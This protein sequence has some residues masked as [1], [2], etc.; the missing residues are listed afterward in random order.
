MSV[1]PKWLQLQLVLSVWYIIHQL[2]QIVLR[3]WPFL[4]RPIVKVSQGRVRGVTAK[5]PNGRRYHYF[6]S[7]PYCKPPVGELRFRPPV[8]LERFEQPVLN[9][10]YERPD[11]IHYQ[12]PLDKFIFGTESSLHLSVFT[13]GLPSEGAS[14]YPVIVFLPSGGFRACTNS[15]FI[16][17]PEPIVLEGVVVVTVGY[18]V[19]PLGF[20][21]LPDAGIS[22]NAGLKDQRLALKWV[23]ENINQF[24]GDAGNVTLMGLSAGAWSAYL[25]YL[26]PNSRKYFHRIICQSGDACTDSVFQLDPEE[27]A[28]KLAQLLGCRGSTDRDVLD[29]LT[30]A[31]AKLLTKLQKKICSS[32][33]ISCPMRFIFRPVIERDLTADS[34]ICQ[35]P[36]QI[37]KSYDTLRMPIMSNL[38][39]AE[40]V[41]G[42]MMSRDRLDQYNQEE[43]LVPQFLGHS[44]K[45]DRQ[46]V[47]NEVKQFYFGDRKV[48]QSSL[49]A[50][51]DFMTDCTFA[52]TSCLSAEWIARYQPNVEHYFSYFSYNGR[53]NYAKAVLNVDVKEASHGDDLYYLFSAPFVKKLPKDSDE[54]R[55]RE[56]VVKAVTNFAKCGNPTP[57]ESLLGFQWRPVAPTAPN[58]TK[59]DL[60]SLE[61]N[62]PPRMIRNPNPERKEFW[63]KMIRENTNLLIGSSCCRVQPGTMTLKWAKLQ[64]VIVLWYAW[65]QLKQILLRFWPFL[66]RPIVEV[67]QGGVQG[68]TARLPNGV[69]YHYFKC[70]PYSKAPVG[71]LRFRS[72]V[73]LERFEQP[74]LD[75]SYERPDFVQIQ[76]P[77]DLRVVGVESSL[78]LS[79]FTPGLPPEGASKYPVIVYIPGGGLRACTNSTFI[80]DPAHIV[81]QGVVVV[82]V[83]YRV[84][85]LGFLCLPDAGISGNAGLKDQRLA[86]KWVHE[87]ISKFRGDTENVTLMGQSAGAWSAYLHY[88][89]PNSRKYFHRAIFQSGDT[90]TE[91]VFQ[92]DPEEKARKLAKLLGCRGSS[93]REVLG[94]YLNNLNERTCKNR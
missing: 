48:G 90:C 16:F 20:L 53:L 59:F 58:T 74:V 39:S 91:S 33:E 68:V 10:S 75:C 2:K 31:P 63:R 77:H 80:Y 5:L 52:V 32:G 3:F 51:C 54:Y 17:D 37:L 15:T 27:K 87:N 66:E 60:D 94:T 44:E 72:P 8:P 23:H 93:D 41:L 69:R 55:V 49:A 56:I 89:S 24:G 29:T 85:P 79:V 70:I 83:A 1:T 62:L 7:I 86:L 92:L 50:L 11:F 76:G 21:C 13:P 9:C 35:P 34:I 12:A 40:G 61:V 67:R 18:R 84:G 45:M 47:G 78:H 43:W 14:R 19:G 64:L 65:H 82:T 42:I 71:E 81:Q 36:E 4:E 38:C 57:D 6:K 88:L 46:S 28:R 73:P 22:G 25:H 30:K 26:A